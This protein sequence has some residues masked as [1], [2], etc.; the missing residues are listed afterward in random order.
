MM[1]R[2]WFH[3]VIV[4]WRVLWGEMRVG[5]LVL[6]RRRLLLQMLLVELL[7]LKVLVL[8]MVMRRVR[9][10][11]RQ[12]WMVGLGKELSEE[13]GSA[14]GERAGV[15]RVMEQGRMGRWMR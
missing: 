11:R 4:Y 1:F 2:G 9:L 12:E 6:R 3:G 13:G 10:V 5:Q 14:I 15:H 7:L 8:Q